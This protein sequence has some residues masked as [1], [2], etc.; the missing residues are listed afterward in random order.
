[1][2][3]SEND[4]DSIISN[5]KNVSTSLVDYLDKTKP[6]TGNF[7]NQG[8]E[9]I[10]SDGKGFD[11]QHP[12]ADNGYFAF[13]IFLKE[14]ENNQFPVGTRVTYKL[15]AQ[16]TGYEGEEGDIIGTNKGSNKIKN[17]EKY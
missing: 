11:V 5:A 10:I 4:E 3:T 8:F 14:R 2:D 12:V 15:P 1:M 6:E 7:A 16:V 9:M 17:I 13:Q